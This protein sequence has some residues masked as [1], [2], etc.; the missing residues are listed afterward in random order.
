MSFA[1]RCYV[2]KY[3][4]GVSYVAFRILLTRSGDCIYHYNCLL[5]SGRVF[6][7]GDYLY[8]V[9]DWFSKMVILIPC[10]KIVMGAGTTQLF[11]EHVWKHFGLPSSIIS[12]RDSQF[13]G[14]FWDSLWSLMDTKLKKSMDFNPQTDGQTEVVNCTMV[15]MLRGY[16]SRHLK[17]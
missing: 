15:H 16:N 17:T 11:F 4:A 8:I 3:V 5:D 6:I 10:K 7:S 14:H 12:D 1:Q 13:L 2:T 9:V